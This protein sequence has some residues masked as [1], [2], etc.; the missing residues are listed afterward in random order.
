MKDMI[1]CTACT[2]LVMIPDFLRDIIATVPSN[3]IWSDFPSKFLVDSNNINFFIYFFK[4]IALSVAGK[5][6]QGFSCQLPVPWCRKNRKLIS[7][8]LTTTCLSTGRQLK[9]TND[10]LVIFSD[11]TDHNATNFKTFFGKYDGIIFICRN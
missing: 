9:S 5:R 10:L 1:D 6:M 7:P 2:N 3:L 4:H 11:H 8:P